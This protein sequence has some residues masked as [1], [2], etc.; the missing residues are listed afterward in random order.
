ML[1]S[2][3]TW[4]VLACALVWP[5]AG[6]A[7]TSDAASVAGVVRD[8]SGGVLPGVTVEVASPALIEKVRSAVTD[9]QGLY[10]V[11]DLRPGVYSVTF[12]LT[13]FSTVRR[14]GLEL[15]SGF[16]ASINADLPVGN[17]AETVTVSGQSP[18]VDLQNVRQ[19][20][21]V[22]RATLDVL[23][24]TG[25]IN[26]LAAIIPGATLASA[27]THSVG[28]LDER[29][30]YGIHGSS[31][32]DNA[33][34][35]AGMTQRLQ[36]GAAFVFNNLAF[37]QVS[38][39]TQGMNAERSTGGVQMTMIPKDGGNLLAGTIRSIHAAP[40][41]QANNVTS[42]LGTR[43]LSSTPALKRHYDTGIALGG[44]IVR[45]R[46]W[47]FGS[48]RWQVNQQYQQ[49][50]FY[51]RVQGT[52]FYEPDLDRP[53]YSDDYFKM[54][55][56]RVTWQ[57][58][59]KH[60]IV[61]S[62]DSQRNQFLFGL[63]EIFP[64]GGA[65]AAPEAVGAHVYGPNTLPLLTWT[66][67]ASDKLLVEAG[68]SANIF[69]NNTKRRPG[70]DTQVIQV[71]DLDR[72]IRYGSRATGLTHAGGYRVQFNRQ[73]HQQV[74][75]SYVTG[76]H[77]FKVGFNYDDYREGLPDR[78]ND[79]NQINQARSY[80][81]RGRTP[82]SVTIWAVPFQT[83][84]RGRDIAAYAQDQWTFQRLTLNLGVRIN[85]LNGSVPET[86]LPAGPFVPARSFPAVQDSPNYWNIN[87]RVGAA[88]DLFGDS[89]TALKVSLGRFN[90]Y[91]ANE[92]SAAP[93]ALSIPAANQA[94]STTRT[95]G[96]ANGNY[97]PDCDLRSS[98]ANGECGPWSDLSFGQIRAANTRYAD[99]ATSGTNTQFYNW[100]FSTSVQRE[101]APNIALNVGYHRTWYGGFLA[102]DNLAV[103]PSDFNPYCVNAP[104]DT[105][106][107][108]A[109][110]QV[111]GLF[112]LRPELFGRVD[113]LVTKASN[114]GDQTRVYNGFDATLN[115]RFGS[116]G[117]FSGG[118]ASGRTVTN[119]CFIVD[120]PQQARDGFCNISP[121]WS[122]ETQVKFMIIYPLPGGLQV[123]SIYQNIPGIPRAASY[124][125]TNAEVRPSLGR[126]LGACG[127]RTPC[128]ASTAAFDLFPQRTDYEERL[129]QVDLRFSRLFRFGERTRLQGALDIYNLANSGNV[130]NMTTRYGSAWLN[131]IQIM[132]GRLMK[133]SVQ[134]D[135]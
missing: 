46:L 133:V 121:P 14:E 93:G 131:A 18:V 128:T 30:Q 7:Q 79:A 39:E 45:D 65:L 19:A 97:V 117:V 57:A 113:N 4:V 104:S 85:N 74:S 10:R 106:L 34:I 127:G 67:V 53:A 15:S 78:T 99:D 115:A 35:I 92:G 47:F 25:R 23:P 17:V 36:Q 64:A 70:V 130:L 111:C 27:A 42:E 129:Q 13:G 29:G 105:R 118:L 112:D 84:Q 62:F 54:Y 51:N 108:N 26:H 114:Y 59:Q 28:G 126:D 101:L 90:P 82:Q 103:T 9:D 22:Q 83:E 55:G 44:P 98:A 6:F 77:N 66:Y 109:G 56:L 50:N 95:W 32:G 134:L 49:G 132:G 89:R 5:V 116:G 58:A 41:W 123:S 102:T 52:L 69:Y 124:V 71:T 33:P 100:R 63:L 72:N 24:T 91:G 94:A 37:E 31:P 3:L 107:P 120:S 11:V 40:S 76:S 8:S 81:F 1:S 110:A 87:P 48:A 38:V 86:T 43:G 119:D 20:T 122:A 88:Y 96:D 125:A 75:M 135:F 68:A 21:T 61:A 80:T 2:R 60:K 12:T 16:T 73:Y